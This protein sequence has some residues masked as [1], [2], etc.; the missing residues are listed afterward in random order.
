MT[1]MKLQLRGALTLGALIGPLIVSAGS[2]SYLQA[3]VA[4]KATQQA[5]KPANPAKADAGDHSAERTAIAKATQA[6][7][8]AYSSG[9]V[10]RVASHLSEGAELLSDDAPPLRGRDAIRKALSKYFAE[11]EPKKITREIES[12]RSTSKHSAVEEG[13]LKVSVGSEAPRNMRYSLRLV[14]EDGKW[15]ITAMQEQPSDKG[16]L[17]DLEWLIGSWEAKRADAE[18]RTTYEWFGDKSFIRCTMTVRQKDRT[19]TTM[20]IIGMDPRT[21]ELRVWTFET[22][23][24]FAEG[25]CT[26]EGNTWLFETQGVLANGDDVSATNILVR[27]N[28]DTTTWQPVNLTMG[29]EKI[30]DLPPVKVTRLKTAK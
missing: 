3:Q 2:Q 24:G 30:D 25:T 26:R 23:G 12:V 18:L 6:F 15:L 17:L 5:P 14:D 19:F 16:E 1:L 4:S 20:Q 21:E 29:D 22:N 10:D 11:H 13:N 7:V 28:N 8:E 27:V 9:D